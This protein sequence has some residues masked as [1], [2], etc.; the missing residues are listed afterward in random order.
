[1]AAPIAGAPASLGG[2]GRGME[3]YPVTEP[4]PVFFCT[5]RRIFPF[6]AN[7]RGPGGMVIQ[8]LTAALRESGGR[9]R[10]RQSWL[11]FPAELK[12]PTKRV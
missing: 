11:H 6:G 7:F 3:F 10:L 4:R 12:D 8:V 5:T 2:S 9:H 1:M